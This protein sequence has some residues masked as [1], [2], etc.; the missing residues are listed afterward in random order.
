[1]CVVQC[2]SWTYVP[3]GCVSAVCGLMATQRSHQCP[4][5]SCLSHSQCS[6]CLQSARCGWCS[7]GGLNGLG[8]C[9]EGGY[10]GPVSAVGLCTDSILSSYVMNDTMS[11]TANSAFHPFRV[12]K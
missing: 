7:V 10:A 3:L 6:S 5:V 4:L 12:D 8:V 1:V 2:M 11:G 9:M